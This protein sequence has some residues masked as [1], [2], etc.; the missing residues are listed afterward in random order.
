[1][2]CIEMK[3]LQASCDKYAERRH[4]ATGSDRE[5]R[6]GPMGSRRLGQFRVAYL[7]HAHRMN[8]DVCQDE[9]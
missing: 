7:I 3:E 8:C 5:R 1:M 4:A 2:R 6:K 9:L